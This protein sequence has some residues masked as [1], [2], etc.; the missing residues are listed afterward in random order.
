MYRKLLSKRVS[1]SSGKCYVADPGIR[2]IRV[3]EALSDIGA[4]L[5]LI[6]Y[7]ELIAAT[8]RQA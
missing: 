1:T 7:N 2:N 5:E 8:C 4:T 3:T 6:V